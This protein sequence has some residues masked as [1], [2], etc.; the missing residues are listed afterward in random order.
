MESIYKCV[1]LLSWA[2]PG[3]KLLGKNSVL[4]FGI[5]ENPFRIPELS[6]AKGR[7][8]PRFQGFYWI[9]ACG[10]APREFWGSGNGCHGMEWTNGSG[11]T[12]SCSRLEKELGYRDVPGKERLD[13]LNFD[14]VFLNHK[15]IAT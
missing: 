2:P 12:G 7:E 3:R 4:M 8:R 5:S 6:G 9:S 15:F 10:A 1:T 13:F 14:A 11:N